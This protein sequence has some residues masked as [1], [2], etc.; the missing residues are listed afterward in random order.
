MH[1]EVCQRRGRRT[2][3][4]PGKC[5]SLAPISLSTAKGIGGSGG[6]CRWGMFVLSP[7]PAPSSLPTSRPTP[8]NTSMLSLDELMTLDIVKH[9]NA[10]RQMPS[11]VYHHHHHRHHHIIKLSPVKC[12]PPVPFPSPLVWVW[13]LQ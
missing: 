11:L 12:P 5:P 2:R 7:P 10:R 8:V 3:R 6:L 13:W 4:S 1:Q 9:F